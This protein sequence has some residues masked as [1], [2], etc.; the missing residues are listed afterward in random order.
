MGLDGPRFAEL[1]ALPLALLDGVSEQLSGVFVP[2]LF[3]LFF[4]VSSFACSLR[5]PLLFYTAVLLPPRGSFV[6]V[7]ELL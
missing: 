1:F 5:F 7:I 3:L 4:W 6:I 2:I